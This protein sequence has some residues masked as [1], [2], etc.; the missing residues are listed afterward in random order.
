MT[1]KEE[2]ACVAGV[3]GDVIDADAL[4]AVR[5]EHLPREA[6]RCVAGAGG[7][8]APRLH[9]V[10]ETVHDI[11]LAAVHHDARWVE[12]LAVVASQTPV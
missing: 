2:T 3:V 6:R 10:V 5:R 11:Q 12:K 7:A 1:E 8:R 4:L 9:A